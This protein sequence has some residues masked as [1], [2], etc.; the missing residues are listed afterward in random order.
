M[1][2]TTCT[3]NT[4][5]GRAALYMAF[6]KKTTSGTYKFVH[7]SKLVGKNQFKRTWRPINSRQLAREVN[8]G[9]LVIK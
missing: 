3:K 8:K 2:T 5:D 1:N 4:K 9:S 6:V 7:C